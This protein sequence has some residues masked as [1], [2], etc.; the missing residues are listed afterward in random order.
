MEYLKRNDLKYRC[1]VDVNDVLINLAVVS[2]PLTTYWL[3]NP[4][5]FISS[6][7]NAWIKR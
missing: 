6:R 4:A 3:I 7:Y 1:D 2:S 5:T